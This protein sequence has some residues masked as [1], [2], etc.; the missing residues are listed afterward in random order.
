MSIV[1]GSK[2]KFEGKLGHAQEL[3]EGMRL[4]NYQIEYTVNFVHTPA[5]FVTFL[6]LDGVPGVGFNSSMFVPVEVTECISH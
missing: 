3:A 2:V 4:L 1:V 6:F 5:P